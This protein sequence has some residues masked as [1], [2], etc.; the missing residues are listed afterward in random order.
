LENHKSAQEKNE[1]PEK[2]PECRF[3]DLFEK[4]HSEERTRYDPHCRPGDP[5]RDPMKPHLLGKSRKASESGKKKKGA[6]DES[7][8]G[9]PKAG[10]ENRS[11]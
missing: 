2:S 9:T 11:H 10:M 7:E 8:H 1:R 4:F 5:S 6:E 3:R